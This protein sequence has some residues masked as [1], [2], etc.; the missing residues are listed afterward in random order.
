VFESA[1]RI[2]L[3]IWGDFQTAAL[4]IEAREDT[5]HGLC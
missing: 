4:S 3:S 2:L 5:A 1:S